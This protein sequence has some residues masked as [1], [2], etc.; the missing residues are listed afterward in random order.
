[1]RRA[2]GAAAEDDLTGG[3]YL[4]HPALVAIAQA[5]GAL[6]VE[7]HPLG[8]GLADHGQVGAP[9][10]GK[11]VGRRDRTPLAA[12]G[13]VEI[14]RHLIEARALLPR[15]VEVGIAG[16]LQAFA[17]VEE[18][19]RDGARGVLVGHLQEAVLA[20]QIIRQARVALGPAEPRQH[21]VPVPA[22]A[23]ETRPFVV[24]AR[25]TAR[26]EHGVD[27]ARPAKRATARLIAAPPVEAGLW[28][29]FQRPIVEPRPPRHHR[30]N[31]RG[32]ADQDVAARAACLD[33]AHSHRRV[34]AQPCGQNAPGGPAADDDVI[35]AHAPVLLRQSLCRTPQNAKAR[36]NVMRR[37][38]A[39]SIGAFNPGSSRADARTGGAAVQAWQA[40][41]L[42]LPRGWS[43]PPEWSG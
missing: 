32:S 25:M 41:Q 17:G 19:L 33:E 26:V 40:G 3:L 6:A 7:E 1:M 43:P 38:F 31:E 12:I 10:D 18:R 30:R 5:G 4:L 36:R 15:A 42:R 8:R 23:A 11:E 16:D 14:L 37:A 29:R 35:I 24:I 13:A 21:A 28:H 34:F 22:V 39:G 20:V 9:E 27:R 2:E